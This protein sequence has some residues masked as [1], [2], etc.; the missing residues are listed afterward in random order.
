M[1]DCMFCMLPFSTV[2]I[3]ILIS[4]IDQLAFAK[5][6]KDSTILRDMIFI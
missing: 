1:N 6:G 3:L 2:T 4:T 5:Q